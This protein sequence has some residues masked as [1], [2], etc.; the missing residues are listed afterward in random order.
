MNLSE[1]TYF[2]LAK[3][4]I[5]AKLAKEATHDFDLKNT[6]AKQWLSIWQ[7]IRVRDEAFEKEH[8]ENIAM[9]QTFARR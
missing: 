5:K 1:L 3:E 9:D 2:Q 4:L 8:R 7:E 6:Y